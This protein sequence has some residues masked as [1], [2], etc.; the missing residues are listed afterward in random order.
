MVS[1][2]RKFLTPDSPLIQ[3]VKVIEESPRRIAA[4]VA[5]DFQLL[6][7]LT[8]GDVRRCL[9]QGGTLQTPVATAMNRSPLVAPA[10]SSPLYLLDLMKRRN[11]LALPI[12]DE[13]G[14][15]LYFRHLKDLI[16]SK[17]EE[18]SDPFFEF[19][20]IIAG[21]EGTR[22]RPLTANIPKP[23]LDIGGMPLLERQVKKLVKAKIKRVYFAVN[24]LSHMIEDYFGDGR[25]FGIEIK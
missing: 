2:K 24:Y 17:E 25:N 5:G 8:D 22:L 12:V 23:M 3:A 4:V 15:F 13:H 19:A 18:P 11:V 9:L 7:T 1:I 20:V 10:G 16:S 21:G 14:K 6:G